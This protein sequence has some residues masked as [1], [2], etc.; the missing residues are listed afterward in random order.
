V[1]H[2]FPLLM[3]LLAAFAVAACASAPTAQSET[4]V[5]ALWSDY[6]AAKQGQYAGNAGQPSMHWD[7][8]EQAQWPMY[9]LAGFYLSDGALPEVL[10]VTP[11][12]PVADTAYR[13][14]TRFW[15][16]G[17]TVRD[18]SAVPELTMTVFARRQEG[19][20]VLAN[21]L[22][23]HTA[24]W[25]RET[26]GRVTYR[27]APSLTFNARRAERAAAFVDSLALA[28]G[29]APP[30]RLDYYVTESVDQA[31]ELL[32]A[33]FPRTF[34]A[35][36]GFAKP[37]NRQVFS[38]IPSLGEE[39]RHEI[40]HVVLLPIIRGSSTSLLA[41]EGV[42]TWL[43]GTAGR[44]YPSAV[45][46]LDSLLVAHPGVTLDRIVD[47]RIVD[48]RRVSSDIRNAAGAVL[49]DMVHEAGGVA[50]LREYLRTPAAAM[51]STLAR[52]LAKPWADVAGAWRERVAQTRPTNHHH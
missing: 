12:S 37:V 5:R 42:P 24:A 22:P 1:S 34:G 40:A 52:L 10:S 19:R 14:I 17:T 38:G 3:P 35:A 9:D 51:R 21:A 36:G 15:P 50:A 46:Y 23:Y 43:G 6:L 48:D 27:I 4:A 31:L 32:G 39:Y 20:W 45:R 30:P 28:F 26:R 13:I 7:A 18:S 49:A 25:R 16:A 8:A 41:S 33:R 44:D 2:R 47:D 11:L 29:V